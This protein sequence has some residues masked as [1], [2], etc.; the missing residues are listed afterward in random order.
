[1][2][3]VEL[4]WA[5]G[6]GHAATRAW[7]ADLPNHTGEVPVA[8]LEASPGGETDGAPAL[9]ARHG[10]WR[11]TTPAWALTEGG[12]RPSDG[13]GDD[14]EEE[15]DEEDE[16]ARR[17]RKRRKKERRKERKRRKK[18]KKAKKAARAAGMASGF[19]G[20]DAA[21]GLDWS[22]YDGRGIRVGR[23][24]AGRTEGVNRF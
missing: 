21:G 6:G 10:P 19:G 18:E 24:G 22:C 8:G 11:A 23:A 1:M 3:L 20:D 16:E 5:G 2:R 7:V 17:R 4:R 15:E 12:G 13:S 9:V 14:D